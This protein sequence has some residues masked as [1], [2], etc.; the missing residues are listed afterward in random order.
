M[1]MHVHC[2]PCMVY[3]RTRATI[4]WKILASLSSN[5]HG[6]PRPGAGRKRKHEV[7]TEARFIKV[8]INRS[9]H[10]KWKRLKQDY[11]IRTDPKFCKHLLGL[12]ETEVINLYV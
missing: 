11:C 9:D 12:A 6:G 3:Q 4:G 10:E 2:Y 1:R 5:Q 7:S 8:N